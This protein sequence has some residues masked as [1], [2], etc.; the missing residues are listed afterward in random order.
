MRREGLLLAPALVLLGGCATLIH[1]RYQDVTL[2]S[3]PP[4]ATATL[5]ATT[6]ERGPNFLD[7]KKTYTVTTPATLR[8]RRDN[9][10]RVELTKP[11]YKLATTKVVSSYDWAWAPVV[12]GPCEMAGDLPTFDMKGR[13]LPLRFVEAAFYEYPRGFVRAWGRGLRIFSPEALLGTSF[14][15]KPADGGFF[16]DWHAV[17]TPTV[18]ARLEP[19]S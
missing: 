5:T 9:T 3:S 1:G 13:P 8:L 6:S 14:K 15:L 18:S 10:Y 4:G 2:E 12:C 17:G 19:T 16:T 11:G 7:P